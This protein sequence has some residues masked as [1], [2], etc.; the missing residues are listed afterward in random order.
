MPDLI[1]IHLDKCVGCELCVKS[2]PFGAI[3]MTENAEQSKK[4]AVIDMSKCV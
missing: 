2:C 1:T 3:H 4:K